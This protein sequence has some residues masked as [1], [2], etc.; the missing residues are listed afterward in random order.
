MEENLGK[1]P[2]LQNV[3]NRYL[4]L[5]PLVKNCL[6][7]ELCIN[8]FFLLG[9]KPI[10]KGGFGEVWKVENKVTKN[11][12]V[13]KII[14]KQNI[15]KKKLNNQLNIEL[16]INYKVNHPHIV[17]LLNH[18]EDDENFYLLMHYASK[19]QLFN[20]IRKEGRL[21]ERT[22]AQC[23]IE[24]ISA[25]KYLHS[26]DPPIIHRDI[27]PENILLDEFSRVK[28]S[29]FGWSNYYTE[30]EIRKTYCGTPDYISPEMINKSGHDTS[31]DVW[32]LGILIF[33]L[34]SGKPPFSGR[35]QQELFSNIR[36]HRLE[37]PSDF[38]PLA[39]NLVL[40]ILKENPKERITLN[41]IIEHKWIT[42]ISDLRPPEE[43]EVKD[44]KI[45]VILN[46]SPKSYNESQE[47]IRMMISDKKSILQ[48][49][50]ERKE[51][52]SNTIA[53]NPSDKKVKSLKDL[54]DQ[55]PKELTLTK[56]HSEKERSQDNKEN[57]TLLI[58]IN[59]LK[60]VDAQNRNLSKE[61]FI[62]KEEIMKYKIMN[63]NR[64]D[65]LA[66][67]ELRNNE[68]ID[69]KNKLKIQENKIA[70]AKKKQIFSERELS[71]ANKKLAG[72]EIE[73]AELKNKIEDLNKEIVETTSHYRNEVEVLQ[74]RIINDEN[75]EQINNEFVNFSQF[76]DI[77]NEKL[78]ELSKLIQLKT[79]NV[80]ESIVSV[81]DYIRKSEE[82]LHHIIVDKQIIIESLIK[83]MK[84]N[85]EVDIEI[86]KK[87]T[88]NEKN[89]KTNERLEYVK[90]QIT[91]LL[92]YK[93]K[94]LNLEAKIEKLETSIQINEKK[95]SNYIDLDLLRE[96]VMKEK[97]KKIIEMTGYI[98]NI[99]AKLS[100][101]KDFVF[102]NCCEKLDEFCEFYNSY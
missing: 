76:S 6:E 51:K 56:K 93:L 77:F 24:L 20:Q 52:K 26:F 23:L 72:N 73:I 5:S 70:N 35:N 60:E 66:E 90:K 89:I 48:E 101:I 45:E 68:I 18:F 96:N 27:K 63:I 58:E 22:A 102:K 75:K 88:S 92:P 1:K 64:L 59:R 2:F 87:H 86:V 14:S 36:N 40:L 7:R 47:K 61:N 30:D 55:S 49:K 78:G 46:S 10:G 100:D 3:K 19:G 85:F 28:L 99:E 42:S 16:E 29:D 62:L 69:L 9:G 83:K 31:V 4:I 15:I 67:L 54:K 13:V 12:Y 97:D 53:D 50:K 33:E 8:D 84:S 91:E 74:E 34:L 98:T 41:Q 81:E 95:I 25:L 11:K 17:K 44:N 37:W 32:S 94:C 38:P 43:P 79:K 57:L 39:K 21:D 82:S 80:S 65:I 71:S